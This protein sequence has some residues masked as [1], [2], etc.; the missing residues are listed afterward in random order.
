MWGSQ[1]GLGKNAFSTLFFA[2]TVPFF[3]EVAFDTA[4]LGGW[5]CSSGTECR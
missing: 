4:L 5:G 2:E 3:L 1:L